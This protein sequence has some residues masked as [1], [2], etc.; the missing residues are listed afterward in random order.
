[1]KTEGQVRLTRQQMFLEKYFNTDSETNQPVQLSEETMFKIDPMINMKN[2]TP[3]DFM[4][5]DNV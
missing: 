1:I 4:E 3:Y 2:V 5:I